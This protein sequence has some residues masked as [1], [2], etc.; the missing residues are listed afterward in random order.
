MK[1]ILPLLLGT[2]LLCAGPAWTA[3][4]E[5]AVALS[6]TSDQRFRGRSISAGDPVVSLELNHDTSSGLY[7]GLSG[8]LVATR[9]DGVR[10]LGLAQALGYAGK[11]GAHWT[12][13]GGIVNR[14]YSNAYS[15]GVT[16][17]YVEIY[18]GFTTRNIAAKVYFSPSYFGQV[19]TSYLEI[20][21][22]VR[23]ADNW[24][25]AAHVGGLL[26]LETPAANASVRARADV[27]LSVVREFST[28]EIRADV[29]FVGPN[30]DR[31][32]GRDRGNLGGAI[33]MLISF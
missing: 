28:A 27:S 33:T 23:P 26:P 8:A 29:S 14:L 5:T 12:V 22:V 25:L 30:E 9:G 1:P 10:G 31:F 21:S 19:A 3:R 11:I 6:I 24:R 4:S 32:R 20:D 17:N 13:D 16:V 15:G 18:G 7:L 2:S